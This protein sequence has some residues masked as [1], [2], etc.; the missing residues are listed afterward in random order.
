MFKNEMESYVRI[1]NKFLHSEVNQII[2]N[3]GEGFENSYIAL[4]VGRG[5]H[6]LLKSSLHN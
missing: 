3:S 2:Q 4:Q 1:V 5:S 6:K